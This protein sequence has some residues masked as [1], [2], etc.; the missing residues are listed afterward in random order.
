MNHFLDIVTGQASLSVTD[1]M[2]M[3]VT[4][5]AAASEASARSGRPVPLVWSPEEIPNGYVMA[6]S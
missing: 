6:S 4:K 5:I 1:R 3:A 2:T